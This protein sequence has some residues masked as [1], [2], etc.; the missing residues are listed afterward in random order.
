VTGQDPLYYNQSSYDG[1]SGGGYGKSQKTPSFGTG[2]GSMRSMGS[3][4]TGIYFEPDLYDIEE[5]EQEE[6][7]DETFDDNVA[8]DK[9]VS[10]IN[11]IRPRYDISR[12]ADRGSFAGSSNRYDLAERN[13]MPTAAKGIS[14]FSNRKLYPKGFDGAPVGTGGSGQAFGTTGN[15]RRTGTQYGTSRAPLAQI[16]PE[17]DD[18]IHSYSLQDLFFN[19]E[20]V[21]DKNRLNIEKIRRAEDEANEKYLESDENTEPLQ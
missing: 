13:R 15:Y 11:S 6:F 21:L 17:H 20:D 7:E 5:E 2:I 16:G 12:R 4:A 1:R 10:K 18:Y 3:N 14:P 9:F 8:V 19:D